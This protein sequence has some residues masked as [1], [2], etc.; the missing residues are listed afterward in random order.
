MD[1]T[2]KAVPRFSTLTDSDTRAGNIGSQR[3]SENAHNIM[4]GINHSHDLVNMIISSPKS[5]KA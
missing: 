5:V 4:T 1:Q 3:E 2:L